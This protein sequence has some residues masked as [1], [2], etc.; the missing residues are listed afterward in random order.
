MK[1][2]FL[3]LILLTMIL[4][5]NTLCISAEIPE[6]LNHSKQLIVVRSP[7]WNTLQGSLQRYQRIGL[8]NQWQP[9]GKTI[10]V[11]IGKNGM[12][13]GINFSAPNSGGPIKIEGDGKSPAGIFSIDR[14][15]GF[16][17]QTEKNIK[18]NY[19]PI[20]NTTFCVDDQKSKYY[21][22]V[23]D[24][25]SKIT[26]P[27]WHSGEQMSTVPHYKWGAIVQYN[28]NHPETGRG[29]CIFMHIWTNAETG[30]AGCIAMEEPNV[31]QVLAWLDPMQKPV[32]AL[33]P[34]TEYQKLQK[35]W[36]LPTTP[37]LSK[38]KT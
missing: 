37:D 17:N 19:L 18:L 20:T 34:E 35:K 28:M 25:I 11:V 31:K 29:S 36:D 15:F 8:S 1:K 38:Q 3:N 14:A 6:I 12:G 9:I 33:L 23:I 22:Q 21:N 32:I 30:T 16:S 24:D 5:F 27:D 26:Q 7:G 13:W 4:G 2:P 10:P